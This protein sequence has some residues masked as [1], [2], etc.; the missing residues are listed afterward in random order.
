MILPWQK[1]RVAAEVAATLT[2][3]HPEAGCT[4]WHPTWRER[5]G[6]RLFPKRFLPLISDPNIPFHNTYTTVYLS[7]A[8]RLRMLVSGRMQ[9]TIR[10]SGVN[11]ETL[12][13]VTVVLPPSDLWEIF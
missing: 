1:R 9:V 4:P 11:D 8:D 2:G 13:S 6:Y 3:G 5:L 10:T 7:W 12:E